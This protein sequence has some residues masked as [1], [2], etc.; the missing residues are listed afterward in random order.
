MEADYR[1]HRVDHTARRPGEPVTVLPTP[2]RGPLVLAGLTHR[3]ELPAVAADTHWLTATG[4]LHLTMDLVLPIEQV[5]AHSPVEIGPK[6]LL[7]FNPH[8][9]KLTAPGPA[10][11]VPAHGDGRHNAMIGRQTVATSDDGGRDST[12]QPDR[13]T[14]RARETAPPGRSPLASSQRRT[15]P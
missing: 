14:G 2:G 3:S 10:D 1:L 12:P 13:E 9:R 8:R 7:E 15:G 4:K 5:D 6:V 11:V